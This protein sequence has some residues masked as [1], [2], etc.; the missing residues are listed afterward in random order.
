[1]RSELI[2]IC[3]AMQK[4]TPIVVAT[5]I[6]SRGSTPRTAGSKMIVYGDGR[7]SGSIGGGPIEG[8]VIEQALLVFDSKRARITSYDLRKDS[9]GKD[10]DLICGGQMQVLLEY[11]DSGR[12]NE[13]LYG[14]VSQKI[15]KE[16]PFHWK[17]T[18][19]EADGGIEL[20]RFIQDSADT[21]PV[22]HLKTSLHTSAEGLA[23]V[24]PVLPLHT[25][26]IVGAGHVSREIAKLTR[27]IGMKTVIFDDRTSFA[28][29]SRFP[30]ADKI[31]VCPQYTD[32]FEPFEIT[33][34]SCIIIVTRGHSY[35]KEVLGQALKTS[36]GYIGMM[37]SRK[38][39][40]TIYEALM[41]EG[42]EAEALDRVHCP[43]GLPI[44]AET[45]AEL[46][47]SIVAELIEHRAR[48]DFHG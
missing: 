41:A 27:L 36:A 18:I 29:Q 38:K 23:L 9:L 5:I 19:K 46:A 3:R 42:C 8:D 48:L 11:V 28:N 33:R 13:L 40:N 25:A 37:G 4:R 39:R 15:E 14:R 31:Y 7:I 22:A 10:L 43:I 6:D 24:E 47:V 21:D 2:E 35:D 20:D 12:E 17:A 30:E 44:K 1:M 45:P 16:E 32:I 26:F 34:N